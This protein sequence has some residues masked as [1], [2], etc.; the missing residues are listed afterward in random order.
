MNE[1]ILPKFHDSLQ[2][3]IRV[4]G[5]E[6][7]ESQTF[8]DGLCDGF[9]ALYE[10]DRLQLE[11]DFKVLD[12]WRRDIIRITSNVRLEEVNI[13]TAQDTGSSFI[14]R[15]RKAPGFAFAK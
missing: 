7:K 4:S 9:N 11:C 15:C 13:L 8:L 2:G 12:D 5:N 3:W 1:T 14:E 6:F 10:E